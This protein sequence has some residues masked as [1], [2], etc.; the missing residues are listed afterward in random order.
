MASTDDEPPPLE[1]VDGQEAVAQPAVRRKQK[2][3]RFEQLKRR[4][5]EEPVVFGCA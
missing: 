4:A 2:L 1:S 3:S 5:K